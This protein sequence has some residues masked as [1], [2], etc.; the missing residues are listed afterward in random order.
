MVQENC[1]WAK[2]SCISAGGLRLGWAVWRGCRGAAA[3]LGCRAVARGGGVYRPLPL[4]P[5]LVG[6]VRTT[7][8]RMKA[9]NEVIPLQS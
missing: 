5:E 2:L 9:L 8:R 1:D 7:R 4:A 6:S 3:W